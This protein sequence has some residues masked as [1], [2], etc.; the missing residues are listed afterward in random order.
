M[1]LFERNVESPNGWAKQQNEAGR[2]APFLLVW[3]KIGEKSGDDAGDECHALLNAHNAGIHA[4][5][6]LGCQ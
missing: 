1:E 2:F 5:N 4:E 3:Q 6:V